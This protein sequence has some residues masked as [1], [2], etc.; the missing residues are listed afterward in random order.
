MASYFQKLLNQFNLLESQ[1]DDFEKA[2]DTKLPELKSTDEEAKVMFEV[3]SFLIVHSNEVAYILHKS[4]ERYTFFMDLANDRYFI[5][6]SC[7]GA[8]NARNG[9][10]ILVSHGAVSRSSSIRCRASRAY[11]L[12]CL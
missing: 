5:V 12:S 10:E 7:K 11:I 8:F 3:I 2:A 9:G 4:L 6:L 1:L